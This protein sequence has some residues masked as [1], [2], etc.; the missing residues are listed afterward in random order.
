MVDINLHLKNN[1]QQLDDKGLL[2]H[3]VSLRQLEQSRVSTSGQTWINL[4]GNDYLGLA[5]NREMVDDFYRQLRPD[6]LL[7]NFGPG[8]AASRLMTGNSLL[9]SQLEDRLASLYG[10]ESCLVFNSGYHGNAGILPALATKGDLIL[11][12]KLCHA[13][14]IDGMRL[15]MAE[16]LRYRHLDYDHLEEIL[17]TRR[18]RYNQVFL[19]SESVFSM[20]GDTADLDQLTAMKKKYQCCLYL[21]EAHAVGVFG[22]QGLGLAEQE[23]VVED[24]DLLFGTFGKAMAGVGGFVAC[25]RIIADYLINRARTLIFTTGLPPVCLSWLLYVV[26]RVPFMEEER[27][28]LQQLAGRMRNEFLR[29]GLSVTGN[30][31]IVPVIIG[32][33]RQAVSA[34]NKL[35]D[36]GY[37]VTAVRPPTVPTGTARLRL[38]FSA[39][40]HENELAPLPE[41]LASVLH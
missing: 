7:E 23:G 35:Q 16:T 2:R 18:D 39:A 9:Y 34:A 31:Q 13:S 5:V 11:A 3:I 33:S 21:D 30:S 28:R 6:T 29:N 32:D 38:S 19:V 17:S 24:I 40:M 37:W 20:D 27:N 4:S 14:L 22:R 36:L 10:K 25:S 15:S 12:D 41:L 8:A 1:L 26:D